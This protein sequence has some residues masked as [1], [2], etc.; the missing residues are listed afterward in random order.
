MYRDPIYDGATDPT[1]VVDP[2]GVWLMF[3]TQRRATHPDPGPDVA[4]VH[5]TRIAVARSTDGRSWTYAGTL[6]PANDGLV[7]T[8]GAPPMRTQHTY[9]APEV[10]RHGALWH[11]YVSEIEGV[12]SRWR[13]HGRQIVEYRSPDLRSW[14]RSQV[15]RLTSARVIDAAVARTP[16]RRWRL[17][18]KDEDN[19][20]HTYVAMSED[21]EA[22]SVEGV[23]IDG[24]PH[25]GPYAFP[26]GGWWWMLTD[27]WSGLAVYRSDDA[28]SWAR[29]EGERLLAE[30]G[31]EVPGGQFGRH[32]SVTL[33]D[34][35]ALLYYFTHPEWDGRDD[36][37]R[38]EVRHR[39]SSVHVAELSVRNGRLVCSR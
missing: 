8:P 28:I 34:G 18:Y 30:S 5:G 21:L 36:D 12:P 14:T 37:Q 9:W 2:E 31:S 23:A 6:E 11:M 22:W 17:W 39:P 32:G 15:L 3:Y 24:R 35:R 26:L 33:H 27:E 16:D 29:Q 19:R 1:V 10:V 20:A 4:W 7:M 13:G 25:E 38:N